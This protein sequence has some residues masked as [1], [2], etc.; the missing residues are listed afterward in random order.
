MKPTVFFIAAAASLLFF[1]TPQAGPLE[2]LEKE[3]QRVRKEL[4]QVQEERKSIKKEMK[5]DKSDFEAYQS[6]TQG[7]IKR[8]RN[9]IDSLKLEIRV[10]KNKNDSISAYINRMNMSEKQFSILQDNFRNTILLE[11]DRISNLA[12][13]LPP[14]SAGGLRAAVVLLK[15]ELNTKSI[16]NIEAVNRLNEILAKMEDVSSSIQIAQG[17]SPVPDVRGTTYRIRIGSFFEAVVDAKAEK[18][19]VWTGIDES[20]N[21]QWEKGEDNAVAAAILKA[22]KIREGKSTPKLIE[23][24]IALTETEAE[25]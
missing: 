23:L 10:Q 22:V 21:H 2:D 11:C 6:R 3:I 16:D 1:Q 25:K 14:L 17:A 9:D 19:A 12:G 4:N 18:Y 5:Q 20:G 7:R 13:T 24:P 15:G 8:I